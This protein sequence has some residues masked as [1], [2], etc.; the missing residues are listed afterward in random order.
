MKVPLAGGSAIELGT[1]A[2]TLPD[3]LPGQQSE[4]EDMPAGIAV[5]DS[6]VYFTRS[7][8]FNGTNGKVAKISKNGG[9]TIA[10]AT[11]QVHPAGIVGDATSLYFLTGE[12][13]K[14]LEKS[15]GGPLVLSPGGSGF[16]SNFPSGQIAVDDRFLYWVRRAKDIGEN[17]YAGEL[18]K[19]AK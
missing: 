1:D 8:T 16:G 6:W 18:Y 15:G 5:D 3:G 12:G 19:I 2:T 7:G 4:M 14:K 11:S 9:P 13:P 17:I 10:L